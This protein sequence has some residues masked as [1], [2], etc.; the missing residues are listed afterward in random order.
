M[1]LFACCITTMFQAAS[2]TKPNFVYMLMDDV[3]AIVYFLF[4]SF[5]THPNFADMVAL[6]QMKL[7]G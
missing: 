6:L 5:F 7:L 3:S 4:F 2:T 1:V